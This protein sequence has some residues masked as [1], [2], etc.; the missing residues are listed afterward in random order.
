MSPL[1]LGAWDF[2]MVPSRKIFQNDLIIFF[3]KLTDIFLQQTNNSQSCSKLQ[4]IV[5][6]TMT[7]YQLCLNNN[8]K[9]CYLNR[10]YR[11]DSLAQAFN[12]I[13]LQKFI[14]LENNQ[15]RTGTQN[16]SSTNDMKKKIEISI[17]DS[18][19]IIHPLLLFH[20]NSLC[21]HHYACKSENNYIHTL[22]GDAVIS[23]LLDALMK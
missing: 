15:L 19:S 6:M 20:E 12:K 11:T 2:M 1:S 14:E 8:Y 3:K 5:W 16:Q 7:P 4:H 17:I 23:S 22:S 18:Y 9:N 13:I 21:R 10:G